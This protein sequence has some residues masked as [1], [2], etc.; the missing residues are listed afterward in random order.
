MEVSA[1]T[2]IFV[3]GVVAYFMHRSAKDKQVLQMVAGALFAQSELRSAQGYQ[4]EADK[5]RLQWDVLMR[6]IASV[7]ASPKF[8]LDDMERFH[9][10]DL[11][12]PFKLEQLLVGYGSHLDAYSSLMRLAG[13]V[14]KIRNRTSS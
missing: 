14:E 7:E 5:L 11:T 10:M 9:L 12:S 1:T 2:I 4:K 6:A 13:K 8:P 3:V